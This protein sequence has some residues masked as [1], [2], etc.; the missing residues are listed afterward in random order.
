[1]SGQ[2][3]IPILESKKSGRIEPQR[4]FIRTGLEWHGE[5]DPVSRSSRSI[6]DDRYAYVVLYSNVDAQG[7]PLYNA[8]MIK[9]AKVEFYDLKSD[10]WQQWHCNVFLSFAHNLSIRTTGFFVKWVEL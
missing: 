1:M 7:K 8:E 3:H 4:N 5:F 6:C 9:P 10:P 2:S